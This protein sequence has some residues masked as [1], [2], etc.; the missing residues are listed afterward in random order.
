MVNKSE[1]LSLPPAVR[2]VAGALRR[3]GWVSFWVQIV[4]AVVSAIVLF[5]AG[6]FLRAPTAANPGTG[7]GLF[8]AFLGLVALFVATFWAFRY[9]RLSRRLTSASS[10]SRP[11]R[12][13]AVQILQIGLV[14]NLV[15]MLLTILGAQAIIGTLVGKSF[16]QGI[17]FWG[18]PGRTLNF[19]TPVDLL[20]VQANANTIMAH[21]IGLVATL[22]L[23]RC[24]NRQ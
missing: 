5:F 1:S 15:G 23:I 20:V 16:E 19:I 10:Q 2:R 3:V 14:I 18:V 8:F 13:D 11:R 9:T 6:S 24:V 21:F 17:A 4:L 7:S 22:W 12:G